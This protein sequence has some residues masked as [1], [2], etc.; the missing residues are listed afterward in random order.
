MKV[1]KIDTNMDAKQPASVKASELAAATQSNTAAIPDVKTKE[2]LEGVKNKAKMPKDSIENPNFAAMQKELIESTIYQLFF[3][4]QVHKQGI[5]NEIMKRKDFR[6]YIKNLSVK[7]DSKSYF[8]SQMNEQRLR[9]LFTWLDRFWGEKQFRHLRELAKI[10]YNDLQEMKKEA[11]KRILNF[12]RMVATRKSELERTRPRVDVLE[13]HRKIR[14]EDLARMKIEKMKEK[15]MIQF[16]DRQR[17][18][19]YLVAS[20]AIEKIDNHRKLERVFDSDL[21]ESKNRAKS[22]RKI[23]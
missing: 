19:E 3:L 15:I 23:S 5:D 10:Q 14:E 7:D 11:F 17:F 13:E 1:E 9:M 8:M 21:F 20:T 22:L 4:R 2:R 16:D 12:E 18:A 6:E